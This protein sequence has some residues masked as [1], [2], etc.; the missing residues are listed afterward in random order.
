MDAYEVC[1][2]CACH[3]KRTELR[4]PFCAAPHASSARVARFASRMSRA[5][6]L[7]FGSTLT[8]VSCS[9]AVQPLPSSGTDSGSPSQQTADASTSP[10]WDARNP[11]S[12]TE[13]SGRDTDAVAAADAGSPTDDAATE[14]SACAVTGAFTCN[15]TTCDRAS[16]YCQMY[17]GGNEVGCQADDAGF[18]FPPQCY[19][20][21]TCACIGQQLTGTCHCV[22]IDDGGGIGIECIGCYGAPPARLERLLAA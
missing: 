9:G 17:N 21:P 10:G 19:G 8:L 4:C 2:S 1:S 12:A 14:A 18:N 7:A 6:W 11:T 5:Q 20:C 22:D 16:Q 13:D 3:I 15:G